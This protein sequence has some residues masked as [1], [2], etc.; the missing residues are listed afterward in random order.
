MEK[1]PSQYLFV[2]SSGLIVN[3]IV[4]VIEP[5]VIPLRFN[6]RSTSDDKSSKLRPEGNYFTRVSPNTPQ[7]EQT[8][9]TATLLK[10]YEVCKL[11]NETG[12]VAFSLATLEGQEVNTT[13]T[14]LNSVELL[15]VLIDFF[16][17]QFFQ[18]RS[19]NK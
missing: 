2:V 17:K 11:S 6:H 12:K 7:N 18:L 15:V 4:S 9:T 1:N 10:K 14:S 19:K 8:A 16:V 13:S 5:V 3:V